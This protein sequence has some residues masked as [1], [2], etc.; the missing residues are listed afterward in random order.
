MSKRGA[1]RQLTKDDYEKEDE[2]TAPA[3]GHA[4]ASDEVLQKRRIVKAKR[5]VAPQEP[6]ENKNPF[7]GVVLTADPP[8]LFGSTFK[9][10]G[11]AA[12]A[13]SSGFGAA[14]DKPAF[15]F[16]TAKESSG[17]SFGSSSTSKEGFGSGAGFAF[18]GFESTAGSGF[19]STKTTTL[20]FAAPAPPPAAAESILPD[21]YQVTSGEEDEQLLWDVRC[22]SYRWNKTEWVEAG[23]GP[24]KVLEHPTNGVRL[25]QRRESTPRGPATKVIQNLRIEANTAVS[26]TEKTVCVGLVNFKMGQVAQAQELR[27][28][29]QDAIDKAKQGEGNGKSEEKADEKPAGE[30]PGDKPADDKPAESEKAD[31]EKPADAEEVTKPAPDTEKPAAVESPT[32]AEKPVE[33]ADTEKPAES[34][35]A[36][37]PADEPV[38]DDSKATDA[39]AENSTPEAKADD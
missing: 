27:K 24:L 6:K 26:Q 20:D 21:D 35:D 16:G 4:I 12:S 8:K 25:V 18:K 5:P 22:K 13:A 14:K 17:F 32:E 7:G 37:N 15:S 28:I 10:F 2:E 23:I 3:S 39:P 30:Q 31:A 19:G 38:A 34:T 1:E 36:E 29:V 11:E 33:P 9:G